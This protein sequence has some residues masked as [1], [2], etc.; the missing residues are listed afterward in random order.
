MRN[1]FA[2]LLKKKA[3]RE[4]RKSVPMTEVADA[5]GLSRQTLSRF[6]QEKL[7]EYPESMLIGL[8]EYFD[9]DISD[10]L[11]IEEVSEN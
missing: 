7:R 11:I 1:N 2:F 5:T 10:L 6:A 3:Q 4:K 9:C 8:C